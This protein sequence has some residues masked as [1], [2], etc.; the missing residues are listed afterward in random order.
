MNVWLTLTTVTKLVPTLRVASAVAVTRDTDSTQMEGH[1]VVSARAQSRVGQVLG[2]HVVR[3]V[4]IYSY[5][6]I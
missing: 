4:C 5:I 6:Y 1:A 3:G 2:R